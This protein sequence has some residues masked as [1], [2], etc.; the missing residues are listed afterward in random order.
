MLENIYM[1]AY[2]AVMIFGGSWFVLK[3]RNLSTKVSSWGFWSSILTYVLTLLLDDGSLIFKFL[4]VLPR[5]LA[6]FVLVILFINKYVKLPKVL[7]FG[8]IGIIGFF[9]FFYANYMQQSFSQNFDDI[10]ASFFGQKATLDQN[11]ELLFDIKNPSDLEKIRQILKPY[12]TTIEL[13]LPELQNADFSELDDYYT[14]NIPDNFLDK[15]AE[16]SQKLTESGL[17]DAVEENE[18]MS[19][20]FK[21]GQDV[22][23]NKPSFGLN[24]PEIAK[25]WAFEKMRVGE[26]YQIIRQ[27]NIRPV[28]KAKIAI[29]DTGIDSQHEDLQKNYKSTETQYDSDKLGHGTHC[30]GIAAAVSNNAKGIASIVPNSDFVE[31]TSIK[32][33]N[34]SGFGTQLGILKGIVK[35]A[36]QGAAVISMSLGGPSNDAA[37]RAYNQAVMYANKAGAIVVVAAGNSNENAKDFSPANV[38]GVIVVSAIDE[39]L[40]KASF[41]NYISDLKMGIAAPGVNIFSTYPNNT[42]KS[43][44]GTSMATPYVAGLLGF[45]KSVNPD[46]STEKAYEILQKTGIDTKDTKATGK[47]IQADAVLK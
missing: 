36:D 30:A 19:L 10:N 8:I 12:Q 46:L 45:M 33:L 35:A 2:I 18:I 16:I 5:D 40:G 31:V 24:D 20:D 4:W 27:K 1:F 41:S 38:D 34:D 23:A 15:T 3:D 6:L 14:V 43:L 37:Q 39:N 21:E 7:T 17:V 47:F 22:E 26:F 9:N 29:L 13:A 11:A 28:K 32:V 44:N 25:Q 42:Y